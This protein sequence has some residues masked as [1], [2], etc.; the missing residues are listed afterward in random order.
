MRGRVGT[1]TALAALA[2]SALALG[3]APLALADSY[4]WVEHTTSE[5]G[6]QG[7][8]GAWLARSGFVLFGLAVLWLVH[9]RTLRWRQPATVF[10]IVFAVCMVGVAAFSL[11]SWVT[12]AA[13]D[14]IEDL[15]HSEC[16]TVMGFAFAFGVTAVA[17]QRRSRGQRWRA[18]DA[19]AVVASVVL[20]IW[21]SIDGSVDG[22]V[23][24]AM[25]VIAYLWYAREALTTP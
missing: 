21:M 15:L 12:G 25:F 18:L 7:V 13:Y 19:V 9:L 6:G 22:A 23:Q 8:Q 10:H 24:R 14:A 1:G 3:L 4:S 16:A 2:A 11:R 20:P 17:F 5:S